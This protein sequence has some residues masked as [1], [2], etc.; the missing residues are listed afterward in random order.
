ME[1]NEESSWQKD[2]TIDPLALDVEWVRQASLFGKYCVEQAKSRDSISRLKDKRDVTKAELGLAIKKNPSAYGIEKVTEGTVDAIIVSNKSF[3]QICSEVAD[4]EYE[5]EILSGAVR[6]M[7]QKK[8]ALENLVKLQGQ[9]YFAG[10][11]VPRDIGAEFVKKAE[12]SGAREKV[13]RAFQNSK[14][15]K[16]N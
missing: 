8:S 16:E 12:Q 3:Q 15:K 11:S 4:A 7:D 2:V 9:N 13:K 1:R 5:L 10:P 14:V 6:A